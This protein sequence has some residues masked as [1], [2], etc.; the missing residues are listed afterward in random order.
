MFWFALGAILHHFKQVFKNF[1]ANVEMR[2]MMTALEESRADG[3]VEGI[4]K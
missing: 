2:D 4:E 3:I 1:R